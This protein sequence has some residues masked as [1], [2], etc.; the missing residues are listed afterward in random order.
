MKRVKLLLTVISL[1]AVSF[2]FAQNI[3]VTGTVKDASTGELIPYA[4]V[5]VKGTATATSTNDRGQYSI[6]APNNAVLVF[7]YIGYTNTEI[8]INNRTKIDITISPD[9]ISLDEVVLTAYGPQSKKAF[10]GTASVV[11]SDQ[12]KNLNVSSVSKALQGLASGVMVVSGTGQPG[13]NA[14]IRVRGVG[15]YSGSSDP[16]IVV[17]NVV[18]NSNLNTINPND[19]ESFTVLKDANSTALYGSRAANGVILITTKLGTPGKA[20]FTITA[21]F[22]LSQRARKDYEYLGAKDYMETQ[23]AKG[24]QEAVNADYSDANARKYATGSVLDY[25]VYNP[26]SVNNPIGEDGKLVS[27]AKL[28]YEED[29]YDALFRVGKR[30][31]YT[32]QATGGSK[33]VR[34][35]ISG[36]YLDDQGLVKGSEYKRYSIRAKID[37]NITSWLKAGINMGLSYGKQNYPT[38][39]GTSFRNSISW[40]RSVASIYPAYQRNTDGSFILDENGNQ[41]YDYG[42][43]TAWGRDRPTFSNSNPLGTFEY[44]EMAYNR[45]MSNNVGYLEAKFLKDFTFRTTLGVDYY[46]YSGKEYYNSKYGDGSA[47]GGRSERTRE[48]TSTIS[49]TNSLTWDK[50][51]RGKHHVNI[52]LGTES[53]DYQFDNLE[54]EKRGFEFPDTELTY[55]G[56][57]QTANSWA[58]ASRNF[59]TLTRA[60]YD[61]DNRYHFSASFTYDGTSRF[62]KDSRWGAFWSVGGGWNIANE[63]FMQSA[64]RWLN[65]LKL[66]ASYGTS[67]N[68]NIGYFPYLATYETGWNMLSNQGSIVSTLGNNNLTWEK[69]GMLDIGVDFAM[70]DNRFTG[71]VT[72]YDKKSKDLLMARPLPISAGITAYNDNIGAVRNNGVELDL[73]GVLVRTDNIL[74]DLGI[75][76]SYQ[77]NRM[78]SLPEEQSEGFN[79]GSYKRI[80]VGESMYSWYMRDYAGVDTKDGQPMWWKD[81]KDKEGNITGKE[82]TKTYSE[83]TRY[84]VGDAL[85][86]YIGGISSNF[87]WKG[88]YVNILASFSAGNKVLDT[89][90]AGLMHMFNDSSTGYQSSVDVLKRWQ[91]PGDVTDVPIIGN[92]DYGSIS[93]A[94]LRNGSY[95]RL[96][97]VTIGYDLATIRGIKNMG[98]SSLKIYAT[99][100]NLCT[101]FGTKGL[102]PEL[103]VNG[104]TSNNS[105][106]LRVISFGINLE[107]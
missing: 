53:N 88:L 62:H 39:G 38:Q 11:K 12:I 25:L 44:D 79:G 17:D 47:Y 87:T 89:D 75:N 4:S 43:N 23:W 65:I 48:T 37:A 107:F 26:Y 86:K 67:G 97:N 49:W 64:S 46:L 10:T 41:I 7:S 20:K 58:T 40:V 57:L 100:D 74:W 6:N 54:A 19:I 99:G 33:D 42:T 8:G 69:Q 73:K 52:L 103:G 66:R 85:P 60:N 104:V 83:G 80:Q 59:R 76:V 81:T 18:Y 14:T 36:A 2:A 56:V 32:I 102:D 21:N 5:H 106:A 30:Q 3:T 78:T 45:F 35:L 105:S 1:F 98:F 82:T 71:S 72:Y 77:K 13:E 15:S 27:G 34:Y 63:S 51:F 101:L 28:L 94:F 50:T 93:T 9:A 96:R 68:Q 29:W 90:Y 16:L 91:K 84:L 95:L 31:E 70:F 55:G 61:F 92:Q 24:Y 22:G